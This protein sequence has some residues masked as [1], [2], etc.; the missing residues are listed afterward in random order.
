MEPLPCLPC[1]QAACKQAAGAPLAACLLRLLYACPTLHASAAAMQ[2]SEGLLCFLAAP[3]QDGGPLGRGAAASAAALQGGVESAASGWW[4]AE[5]CRWLGGLVWPGECLMFTSSGRGQ[6]SQVHAELAATLPSN[7]AV[8]TSDPSTSAEVVPLEAAS[9]PQNAS[10]GAAPPAGSAAA[11]AGSPAGA[12][13]ARLAV[14]AAQGL[15]PATLL[16]LA[17]SAAELQ[18]PLTAALAVER[19]RQGTTVLAKE[20]WQ[21]LATQVRQAARQPGNQALWSLPACCRIKL[22]FRQH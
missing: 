19:L 8:M 18:A 4:V 20:E 2:L 21:A 6:P 3:E 1:L 16:A 15:P 11:P 10:S 13:S 17:G 14:M 5:F 12:P 9:E 22:P 7:D